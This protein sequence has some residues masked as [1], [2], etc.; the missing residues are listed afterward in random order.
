MLKVSN[1]PCY[2]PVATKQK[3]KPKESW[4]NL[5]F[6]V[7]KINTYKNQSFFDALVSPDPFHHALSSCKLQW[8]AEV[9]RHHYHPPDREIYLPQAAA[10]ENCSKGSRSVC[11]C[12]ILFAALIWSLLSHID[13]RVQNSTNI[14]CIYFDRFMTTHSFCPLEHDQPSLTLNSRKP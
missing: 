13:F 1:T 14:M 3:P 5:V 9:V 6:A 10:R 7:T 11:I 4:D 2:L 8:S 12:L